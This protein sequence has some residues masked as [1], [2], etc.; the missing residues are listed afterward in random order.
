[1]VTIFDLA[2]I[3][4]TRAVPYFSSSEPQAEPLPWSQKFFFLGLWAG[5]L[6]VVAIF[7]LV[8]SIGLY[9][10]GGVSIGAAMLAAGG[11]TAAVIAFAM[12]SWHLLVEAP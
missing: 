11:A 8:L 6:L 7:A 12:V 4:R 2:D 3:A 9:I 5:G 10:I 1:M